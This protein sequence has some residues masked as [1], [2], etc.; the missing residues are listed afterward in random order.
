[1]DIFQTVRDSFS[2]LSKSDLP[3]LLNEID[4]FRNNYVA[5]QNI[6]LKD[7]TIAMNGLKTWIK[8]IARIYKAH[9]ESKL[10]KV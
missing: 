4:E 9:K 5:H 1:M 3:E 6:E 10:E 7:R 8:G 2:K